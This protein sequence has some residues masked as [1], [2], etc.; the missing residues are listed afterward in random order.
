MQP[1][2]GAGRGKMLLTTP[3][4]VERLPGRPAV[5][6]RSRPSRAQRSSR[7]DLDCCPRAYGASK[8][9]SS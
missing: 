2:P 7:T 4:M 8:S 3:Y 6:P 5:P 1:A 9:P